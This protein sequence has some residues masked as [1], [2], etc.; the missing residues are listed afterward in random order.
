VLQRDEKESELNEGVALSCCVSLISCVLFHEKS[1]TYKMN[2]RS[3]KWGLF[4]MGGC[5]KGDGERRG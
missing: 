5:G 2:N 3:V 1:R 4:M